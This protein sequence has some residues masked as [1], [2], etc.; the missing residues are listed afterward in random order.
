M[1]VSTIVKTFYTLNNDVNE[2][3]ILGFTNDDI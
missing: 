3:D 1:V 2:T